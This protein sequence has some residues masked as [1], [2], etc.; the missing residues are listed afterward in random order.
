MICRCLSILS[1]S[2]HTST[3]NTCSPDGVEGMS[4]WLALLIQ[5]FWAQ[6]TLCGQPGHHQI[7]SCRA[8][9]NDVM[10]KSASQFR[11]LKKSSWCHESH[12]AVTPV[13]FP[14][15][16]CLLGLSITMQTF[17]VCQPY[18]IPYHP[19]VLIWGPLSLSSTLALLACISQYDN[20]YNSPPDQPRGYPRWFWPQ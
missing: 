19:I 13:T 4:E 11:P 3:L 6:L 2:A 12:T 20:C 5:C 16:V 9:L 7:L 17:R 15:S 1:C 14:F 8:S 18:S 10:N